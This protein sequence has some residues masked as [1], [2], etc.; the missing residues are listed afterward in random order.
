MKKMRRFLLLVVICLVAMVPMVAF[1]KPKSNKAGRIYKDVTARTVD[2]KS[3]EGIAFVKGYNGWE[4]LIR[5]GRFFPNK[6]MTRREFLTVLH[7]LYGGY[8]TADINDVLNANEMVTSDYCCQK[9]VAMSENLGY[10]ITWSGA[11]AKMRRKDV[12]RYIKIFA[13]YNGALMPRK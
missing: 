12:A 3:L 1:A 11:N 4:G 2:A 13:T 8:V 6:F 9:M 7:K 10:K 5:K